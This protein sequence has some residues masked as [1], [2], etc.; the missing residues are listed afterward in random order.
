MDH[1]NAGVAGAWNEIIKLCPAPWWLI[2]NDDIECAPG[3]LA[4]FAEYWEAQSWL[5]TA[6]A[7]FYGNHGASL[8]GITA[9]GVAR[10]GLFD[11]NIYPA[12]LEDCDMSC[13]MDR[14]GLRRANVPGIAARHGD[15]HLTGSCTVNGSPE[16]ATANAR[17]HGG[18]FAYYRRKWGG[19][20]GEE[21]YPTPFNDPHW[22]LA[23]WQFEP[24]LRA[25]QQW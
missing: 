1:P 20:N 24:A 19:N 25:A 17:T 14:L 2:S 13:R 10:A 12:Y 4:K 16:L 7:M 5:E 6:P 8:F 21:I 11:E 23:H 15:D 3:D 9:A 18:N 22:P